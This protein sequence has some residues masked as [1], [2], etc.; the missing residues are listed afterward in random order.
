MDDLNRAYL[1]IKTEY[2]SR[3]VVVYTCRRLLHGASERR[4]RS[5]ELQFQNSS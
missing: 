5:V 1:I 3:V 2:F 4:G